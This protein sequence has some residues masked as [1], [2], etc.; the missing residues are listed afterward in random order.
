MCGTHQRLD[1]QRQGSM[2]WRDRAASYLYTRAQLRTRADADCPRNTSEPAASRPI[3]TTAPV[4]FM[5]LLH[6]RAGECKAA[7]PHTSFTTSICPQ[8]HA[9]GCASSAFGGVGT[10][11]RTAGLW[12]R[13]APVS[14]LRGPNRSHRVPPVI[15]GVHVLV[16]T[17]MWS[18]LRAQRTFSSHVTRLCGSCPHIQHAEREYMHESAGCSPVKVIAWCSAVLSSHHPSC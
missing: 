1:L 4:P 2:A 18:F 13:L 17:A 3:C 14:C 9:P 10:C 15:G 11:G 7:L 12:P 16:D 8:L 6:G 5:Q